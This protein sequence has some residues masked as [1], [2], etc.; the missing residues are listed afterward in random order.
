MDSTG[1]ARH[2]GAP[3]ARGGSAATLRRGGRAGSP[4]VAYRVL[5][6]PVGPLLVAATAR[7]LVR[8]AY[9]R[10]G[11]DAVL[12]DLAARVSP[13]VVRAPRRLDAWA[14]ELE[15]YFAARRRTFDLALDGVLVAGF[16]GRVQR[17]LPAIAYG[18][19]ESYGQVAREVGAPRAARAVGSACAANPLPIVLPCHRVLRGD[20]T[21][22]GY[23]G[24]AAA[25]RALLALE[26]S[27]A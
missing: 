4:E 2:E 14:R 11:F 18:R 1:P 7:G 21:L 27:A 17:H 13:R 12:D 6:T 24:G 9:G 22:G 26:R 8:V 16:R 25:K 10:Q 20:G 23:A 5:D 3:A 15:E 19:T